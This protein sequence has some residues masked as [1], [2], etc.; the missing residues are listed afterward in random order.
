MVSRER[1][2][3]SDAAPPDARAVK[4]WLRTARERADKA[5]RAAAVYLDVAEQT[6]VR[7]ED[8]DSDALPPADKFL[9]LVMFYRANILELLA[10][11][12]VQ[13]T[14]RAAGGGSGH[15]KPGGP[16]RKRRTG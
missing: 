1:D 10:I 3:E 4:A 9:A 2:H 15:E 5:R 8:P 12:D 11:R 13:G 6:V 16:E 7:W 14:R